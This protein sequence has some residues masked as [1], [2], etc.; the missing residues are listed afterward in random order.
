MYYKRNFLLLSIFFICFVPLSQV[1]SLGKT[2]F[3]GSFNFICASPQGDL[4]QNLDKSLIVPGISFSF[5]VKPCKLPFYVGVMGEYLPYGSDSRYQTVYIAEFGDVDFTIKHTYSKFSGFA[6]LRILPIEKVR[7]RFYLDGLLGFSNYNTS[8]SIPTD[9]SYDDENS[10]FVRISNLNDTV[11]CYG[12][13]TGLLIKVGKDSKNKKDEHFINI[14]VQYTYSPKTEYYKKGSIV[15]EGQ[16]ATFYKY[17][18]T[19]PIVT[20]QVGYTATF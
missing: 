17:K 2:G 9:Y 6:F 5:G 10:D 14:G 16:E 15:V 12:A 18:S 8:S 19:M 3:I 11:L 1:Y 7:L 20:F 13:G 4:R